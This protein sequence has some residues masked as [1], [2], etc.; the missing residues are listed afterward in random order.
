MQGL[1][2]LICEE[3]L[4]ELGL[5]ILEKSGLRRDLINVYK[6]LQRGA[7]RTE[8]G[9]FQQCPVTEQEAMSTN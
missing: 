5:L 2:H 9:F 1:K 4:K 7:K 8:Q 3:G 6:Y